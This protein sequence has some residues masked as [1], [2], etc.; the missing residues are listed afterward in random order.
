MFNQW[1]EDEDKS[2]LSLRL[3]EQIAREKRKQRSYKALRRERA[4]P[5]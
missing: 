3:A 4:C 2:K 1:F 5:A